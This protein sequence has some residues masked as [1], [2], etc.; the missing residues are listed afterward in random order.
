MLEEE[1]HIAALI[2]K[3]IGSGLTTDEEI[4]L[5]RW[6]SI[7]DLHHQRYIEFTDEEKIEVKLKKYSQADS[8]VIFQLLSEKIKVS[9]VRRKTNLTKKMWPRF[10]GV[11][12][13]IIFLLGIVFY[14][15]TYLPNSTRD[16]V[17]ANDIPAG[18]T[19]ARLILGNGKEILLS[20]VDS[21]YL[22]TQDGVII[23]KIAEGIIS[24]TILPKKGASAKSNGLNKLTF[25]TIVTPR[26]GEY[27]VNLADGT[28]I[29]LNA[30]SYL[31]FPA[32]FAG[33]QERKVELN[34][35][36]YFKVEHNDSQVFRVKSAGQL[37]E[38]LG[39]EFNI[40]AYSDE[41]NTKTTLLNGSVEV[42]KNLLVPGQQSVLKRSGELVIKSVDLQEATAWKD[43]DFVFRDEDFRTVMRKIA[44]WYDVN[45]V[46]D[47]SA[48]VD[49][50][51][52]GSISRKKNLSVLLDLME[53]TGSV[54]F[55]RKGKTIK[56]SR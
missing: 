21:G 54:H 35:E 18:K 55:T 32:N 38:D 37:V 14:Y 44:R 29:W 43:G 51:L 45:I 49:I 3:Q 33:L 13:S 2:A 7:S 36:A 12:A 42:N 30:A 11:A 41:N 46:Y 6:I 52:G 15:T 4:E 1:F 16:F 23:S 8:E 25:N 26:G 9:R 40:S 17:G 20:D 48:P 39:T 56:V 27:R 28:Q 19:V 50:P 5:G 24:Y 53:Q 10:V 31:K 22:A 34:G 47:I